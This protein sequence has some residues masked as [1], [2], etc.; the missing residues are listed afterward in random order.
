MIAQELAL[1]APERVRSL[2]LGCTTCGG[3]E[4]EPAAPEVLSALMARGS[5]SADDGVEVMVPY[6]YDPST[7]RS[8]IEEDLAVRRR[9]F[10]T[11]AGYY[12][13]VQG[14]ATFSTSDRIGSLAMPVLVI[15]G[16]TDRLVPVGNGK[17]L[18]RK[19]P[20]AELVILPDASH[21]FPTDQPE[22]SV[23]AV[24][25]FLGRH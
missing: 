4:L 21:V 12:A 19:I 15:H 20:G 13:Q 14:V 22:A 1:A 11:A 7:P 18:A 9:T 5:M 25:E 10:P 16:G 8:R 17:T 23:T 2:V 6:I 24:L 3:P